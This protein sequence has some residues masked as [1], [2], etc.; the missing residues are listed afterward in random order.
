MIMDIYDEPQH[1]RFESPSNVEHDFLAE[2]LAR[3]PLMPTIPFPYKL[4]QMLDDSAKDE[5]MEAIISWL[6]NNQS[7]IVHD[8]DALVK[9]VLPRYFSKITKYRSFTRQLNSYGFKSIFRGRYFHQHLIRGEP[10]SC[11]YI[12]RQE[13][14]S[15]TGD[16]KGE[17]RRSILPAVDCHKVEANIA[18]HAPADAAPVLALSSNKKNHIDSPDHDGDLVIFHGKPFYFVD[19]IGEHSPHQVDSV[20]KLK[21]VQEQEELGAKQEEEELRVRALS[22]HTTCF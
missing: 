6:P 2:I 19:A 5:Q 14:S 1:Q 12:A 20:L 7:F 10:T 18:I 21:P 11:M 22:F 3:G 16:K 8:K 13:S 9:E 17:L 15:S 4:Q